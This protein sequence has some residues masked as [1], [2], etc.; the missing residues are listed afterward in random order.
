[1]SGA[2]RRAMA[3]RGLRQTG[4]TVLQEEAMSDLNGWQIAG[5]V[6]LALIVLGLLLNM[7]DIV[8]YIKIRSM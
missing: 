8:R 6:V 2:A 5:I 1:M 7:K 4:A 3:A